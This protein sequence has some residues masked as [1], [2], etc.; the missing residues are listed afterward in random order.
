ML[1][2]GGCDP[3]LR[4]IGAPALGP[5]RARLPT[6]ARESFAPVG[7]AVRVHPNQI[8]RWK[9]ELLQRADGKGCWR[10]NVFVERL[11]KTIK[12]EQVYLHT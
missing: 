5:G 12:Y 10:D 6:C 7:A 2:I 8:T 4:V 9:T 3:L 1:P 11:R